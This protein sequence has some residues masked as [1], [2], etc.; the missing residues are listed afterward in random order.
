[1]ATN[2]K[3]PNCGHEFPLEEAL[4]DELK[5]AIEK[6]KQELR[7]KMIEYRNQKEE[8]LRK[9]D[10]AFEVFK[11]SQEAAY[12]SQLDQELKKQNQQLEESIRKSMH[13]DFENQLKILQDTNR[14]NEEKLRESRKKEL[15]FLRKE[16]ELKN[17]EAELE[18]VLHTKLQE[19]RGKL[20]DEIRKIEEQKNIAKETEFQLRLKE[21]EKQLE[22]QKKLAEEMR[23]KA[24]QG[25]MQLQGEV[26]E[27]ALEEMLRTCFPFDMVSEVGKGVRGADCILTIR[28]QFGQECGSI[29]FESKRTKVFSQDWIEKLKADCRNQ[30]ADMAILV[31]QNMPADMDQFGE[32]NGIWI[33]SF[34]EVK[35]LVQVLRDSIIKISN[36]ARNQE[37]KGDKMHMLYDY[38]TSNEFS[39]QWKAIRE[40]FLSMKLSIQRERDAMEKLWKAREKQL[41]KVLL[42]AAHVK[43]SIEGIA[44]SDMVNLSLAD[45]DPLELPE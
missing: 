12:R 9:K 43:G 29:I 4:N 26:M 24:E 19:E 10:E 14:D 36:A 25:S 30:G 7:E 2:I 28:N 8:E 11:R 22:D 44:G 20:S 39:E 35:P 1:M 6:E 40:G 41:E 37:N 16:Q 23:R 34:A 33:C 45:D 42:N 27:L 31:T 21:L 32:K 3:C 5:E 18:I 17:K 38:L 13:A 15:D